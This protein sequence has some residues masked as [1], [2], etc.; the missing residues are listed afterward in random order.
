LLVSGS[1]RAT[2]ASGTTRSRDGREVVCGQNGRD[3]RRTYAN[4]PI[5]ADHSQGKH[6][7]SPMRGFRTDWTAQLIIASRAF[8]QPP[9]HYELAV[10]I[11]TAGWFAAVFTELSTAI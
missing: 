11:P 9:P 8:M 7:L 5:E 3:C 1:V 4:D 6:R 2:A 10:D